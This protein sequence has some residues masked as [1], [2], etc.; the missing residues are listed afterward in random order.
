MAIRVTEAV[1][2][3]DNRFPYFL[4]TSTQCLAIALPV[5]QDRY[6]LVQ[7]R[8]VYGV[9]LFFPFGKAHHLA[10]LVIPVI[11]KECSG[12]IIYFKPVFHALLFD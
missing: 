12:G 5:I 9:F 3:S 1:C 4:C 10:S 6:Q 2:R 8:G 11:L 7:Y